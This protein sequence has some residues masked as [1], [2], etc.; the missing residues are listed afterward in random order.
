MTTLAKAFQN[1]MQQSGLSGVAV[2][3]DDRTAAEAAAAQPP[4]KVIAQFSDQ[5]AINQHK[6]DLATAVTDIGDCLEQIKTSTNHFH[7][8]VVA[9]STG[10]SKLVDCLWLSQKRYEIAMSL[11]TAHAAMSRLSIH[12]N[13]VFDG[14]ELL[15]DCPPIEPYWHPSVPAAS[16]RPDDELYEAQPQ[17]RPKRKKKSD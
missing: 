10:Q 3:F 1:W 8:T 7:G 2:F 11:Q 17:A 15:H 5:A 16:A 12:C 4:A 9:S 13:A 6:T 14:V